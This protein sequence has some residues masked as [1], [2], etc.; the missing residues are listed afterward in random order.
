MRRWSVLVTMTSLMMMTACASTSSDPSGHKASTSTSTAAAEPAAGQCLVKASDLQAGTTVPCTA[1]HYF[2]VLSVGTFTGTSMAKKSAPPAVGTSGGHFAFDSCTAPASM[3]LGNADWHAGLIFMTVMQPGAA[4]W[5]RGARWFACVANVPGS[6]DDDRTMVALNQSLKGALSKP[7][8]YSLNCLDWR[9]RK[10]V[11]DQV[12]PVSCA[13]PHNAE[14]T[15]SFAG[16]GSK[17]PKS[18]QNSDASAS[19]SAK[20]QAYV[21][22]PGTYANNPALRSGWVYVPKTEWD[23]GDH[24]G[25]CFAF[26]W[27]PAHKFTGSLRSLGNKRPHVVS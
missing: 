20:F 24:T 10:T 27:P 12:V 11:I 4:A 15:G 2:E 13:K 8:P 26:V 14:F 17:Y 1:K 21:A 5:G 9:V 3:Y 22:P 23:A 18:A 25:V 7:G 6:V 16:T 19:C